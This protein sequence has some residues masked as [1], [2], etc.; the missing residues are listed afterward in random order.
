[1]ETHLLEMVTPE[2]AGEPMSARQWVRRSWRQLRLRLAHTGHA[3]SAPTV[4]R[5]LKKHD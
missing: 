5:L 2:T 1:M 3:V 4:S